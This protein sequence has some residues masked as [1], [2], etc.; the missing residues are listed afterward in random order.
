MPRNAFSVPSIDVRPDVGLKPCTPHTC[1]GWRILPS[2][3]LARPTAANR[4]AIA[5][6]GRA[7][8]L[9]IS[10][11]RQGDSV[12]VSTPPLPKGRAELWIALVRPEGAAQVPRGENAGR[13]LKHVGIVRSLTKA[14][15]ATQTAGITHSITTPPPEGG[16]C[17]GDDN[18]FRGRFLRYI[19]PRTELTPW[20]T[21]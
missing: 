8:G 10:I 20:F 1:A 7:P 19:A 12:T 17:V 9:P 3:S 21:L 13:T 4:A 14:G 2:K 11:Q 6:A 5:A 16:G 18:Q 15:T